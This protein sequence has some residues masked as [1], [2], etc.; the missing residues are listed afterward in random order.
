MQLTRL[1]TLAPPSAF[2]DNEVLQR[3]LKP[4]SSQEGRRAVVLWLYLLALKD[5]PAVSEIM[6]SAIADL[7]T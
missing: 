5:L 6:G 7:S 1:P 2:P 3:T 4:P